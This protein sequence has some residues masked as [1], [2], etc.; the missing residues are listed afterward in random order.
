MRF[1][2]LTALC[3]MS[4]AL[5][6]ALAGCG[7]DPDEKA[8]LCPKPYLL[9]DAAAFTHYD[10]HGTDIPNL[11]LSVKITDV[12]GACTG[13]LGQKQ[14]GAH[15]HVVMLVGRGP[16]NGS[17]E[18]DIGYS[19]GVMR[20][21][22]ILDERSLTQ[23]VVFPPNVDRVEVTGQEIPFLFPTGK[24]V[25]GPDYHIYFWLNLSPEDIAL[26]RSKLAAG[27]TP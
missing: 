11:V 13:I 12:H 15:A 4:L 10:G 7:G 23:H 21:G 19:V 3:L 25:S 22:E 5:P 6:L 17:R 27:Q 20:Q 8:Q 24:S 26:N 14:E 9:P 1:A 18:A 16:A 2:G